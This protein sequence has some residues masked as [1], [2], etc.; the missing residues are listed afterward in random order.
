MPE[1][2]QLEPYAL[3]EGATAYLNAQPSAFLGT[4]CYCILCR[5]RT[6]QPKDTRAKHVAQAHRWAIG[7]NEGALT[8]AQVT[9]AY[10]SAWR[11]VSFCD[12]LK[13]SDF[14]PVVLADALADHGSLEAVE[15]R[16]LS[17]RDPAARVAYPAPARG[18]PGGW[19]ILKRAA[20]RLFSSTG[21]PREVDIPL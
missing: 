4:L 9:E 7:A 15:R 17:H 10:C 20:L 5:A 6:I 1:Q 2:P 14:H 11:F 12:H 21:K 3:P 8:P 16:R 13:A 19:G 18:H